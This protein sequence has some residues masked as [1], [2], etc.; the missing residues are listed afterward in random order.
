MGCVEGSTNQT[1]ALG[2]NERATHNS[3]A[4]RRHARRPQRKR[5]LRFVVANGEECTGIVGNVNVRRQPPGNAWG[6]L[7]VTPVI[8]ERDC[9]S[10]AQQSQTW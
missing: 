2:Y 8:M 9:V 10:V 3:A 7:V 5:A 1:E 6:N 4:R